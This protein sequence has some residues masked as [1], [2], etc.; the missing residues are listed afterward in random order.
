MSTEVMPAWQVIPLLEQQWQTD[1]E[2][3][4]TLFHQYIR[5]HLRL[6]QDLA[7]M[8]YRSALVQLK[9]GY[10]AKTL[11]GLGFDLDRLQKEAGA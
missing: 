7:V 10:S 3:A 9:Y 11:N 2:G 1:K 8:L 6:K 5:Y 4:T